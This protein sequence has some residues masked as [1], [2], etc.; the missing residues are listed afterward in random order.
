MGGGNLAVGASMVLTVLILTSLVAFIKTDT[1][2][3]ASDIGCDSNG[4]TTTCEGSSPQSFLDAFFDVTIS[5]I[6]AGGVIDGFYVLIMGGV[7]VV[8]FA[9][10]VGGIIGLI[11][12]GG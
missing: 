8:G 7:L 4:N 12:G 10:V 1:A 5:G 3:S 6:G 11:A 9:L 2:P